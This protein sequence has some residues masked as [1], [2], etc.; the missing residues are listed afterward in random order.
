MIS[1]IKAHELYKKGNYQ[2][3]LNV[4]RELQKIYGED[5]VGGDIYRC[6]LKLGK[7]DEK[8][9]ITHHQKTNIE[10]NK[11]LGD[12]KH[13]QKFIS[14]VDEYFSKISKI[15]ETPLVSVIMTSHNTEDYIESAIYSLLDQSYKNIEIIVVDDYSSDGTIEILD[16]L[17]RSDKRI[18]FFRLNSNLGTYYAKNLGIL[19][20][21]GDVIFFQDSDDIC[22][23]NRIE[24][25]MQALESNANAVA[26]RAA[27][28]R[29]NP[30]NGSIVEVDGYEYKL[31]LIT[32]GVRRSVFNEIGFFNCTTK[33]SDDEFFNRM[34]CY[35]KKIRILDVSQPLYFNTMRS[36]S[37]ISDMVDWQGEST[38]SQSQSV[39]RNNYVKLFTDIH[40]DNTIR[41]ADRF[42]FP[43]IKDILPVSADM[44]KLANP[45]MLVYVNVCSIPEREKQLKR[46]ISALYNQCDFI[47]VYLDGYKKIPDFLLNRKKI[48]VVVCQD[49]NLSIRD[50]GKFILLEQLVNDGLDGYYITVDDDI[51]YPVDYVNSMI[52]KLNY[53]D[54][55]VVLG[56]HG[57]LL[58]KNLD[59]YFSSKRKVFSFY[60]KLDKDKFVNLLGTGT[61]AFRISRFKGFALSS[62]THTGMADIFWAIECKKRN[63]PQIAVSR[64]EN[65]LSEMKENTVTLFHEYK[66]RDE[67]QT[68]L[69]LENKIG[70]NVV[71]EHFS[72]PRDLLD[73]L[74]NNPILNFYQA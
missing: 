6:Q 49:K 9:P 32:L 23:Q 59:R 4:Y 12:K 14:Q 66:D 67:V 52:K 16:R 48:S 42:V 40:K 39:V 47:H 28:A 30:S 60:K 20:S 3:A 54:D 21:K 18:R 17:S 65:W 38:I 56:V 25:C 37:L 57:M 7:L 58:P 26:V 27:Y 34:K 73:K 10:N 22:H 13:V 15:K 24:I 1:F 36:N 74:P 61:M 72:L 53:Y 68:R 19:Q 45:K 62:L 43:T 41:F 44:T 11:D 35:Y 50:N 31:G 55:M 63:I 2:E 8:S 29:V 69:L 33:A 71:R 5:I 64:Y 51:N 70:G 46:V